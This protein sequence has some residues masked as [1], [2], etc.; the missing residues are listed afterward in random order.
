MGVICNCLLESDMD[1]MDVD[2]NHSARDRARMDQEQKMRD[3]DRLE[4]VLE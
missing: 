4:R 2:R 1:K 3:E